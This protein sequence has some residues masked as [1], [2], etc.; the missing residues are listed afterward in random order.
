MSTSRSNALRSLAAALA[1]ALAS[2]IVPAAAQADHGGPGVAPTG[3]GSFE[4]ACPFSHQLSD[5]PLVH[6]FSPGASHL[7][8]FYGSSGTNA[9]SSFLTLR[10]QSTTC[11]RHGSATQQADRSAYWV[12]ALFDN[13]TRVDAPA[14][15]AYYKTMYRAPES[16]EPFPLNLNMIAGSAKGGPSE[17]DAATVWSFRCK[18]ETVV[19][20][21]ETVAPTCRT[22]PLE[23]A[24]RFPDCWNGLQTDSV[25][26]KSHMAYSRKVDG[27]TV[28]TCPASHPR[29]VPALQITLRYPTEGGPGVR[30]A[31]GAINTAHADFMN[32]WDPFTLNQLVHDCLNADHYCGGTDKPVPGHDD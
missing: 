10:L 3:N 1:L 14:V 32:G 5:D 25:D 4:A 9:F 24:I 21:S 6:P 20:G 19:R 31:P 13:G 18:G 22:A 27:D 30:L 23:L 29:P 28:K 26:H 17:V 12:P 7:H 16:I 15:D 8:E 2:A 11:V